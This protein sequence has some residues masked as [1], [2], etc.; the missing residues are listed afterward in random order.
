MIEVTRPEQDR[1]ASSLAE[2]LRLKDRR[3]GRRSNPT[4]CVFSPSEIASLWH[5]PHEGFSASN[6]AWLRGKNVPLPTLMRGKTEGVCLG[7]NLYGG[8]SDPVYMLPQDRTGHMIVV[9]KTGMG[10]STLLHNLIRRRRAKTSWRAFCNAA[11][12]TR[13]K[14]TW[15]CWIWLNQP[16]TKRVSKERVTVN[17]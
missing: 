1:A 4:Q 2:L 7:D 3:Y 16:F 6:V 13:A 11:S 8:R 9:G 5:L 12:P 14:A 17:T 15:W 10:K